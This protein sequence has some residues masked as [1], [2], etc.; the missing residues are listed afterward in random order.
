LRNENSGK[1]RIGEIF[2]TDG[3]RLN[4]IFISKEAEKRK[5]AKSNGRKEAMEIKNKK[6][7]QDK[8]Q[9]I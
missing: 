5:E 8:E 4:L 1:W 2:K 3:V 9:M 7:E 6:N